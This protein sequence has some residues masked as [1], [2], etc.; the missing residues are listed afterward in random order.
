VTHAQFRA[1]RRP[2]ELGLL[3]PT[4]CP[5]VLVEHGEMIID[6]VDGHEVQIYRCQSCG[7]TIVW[8][9]SAALVRNDYP[10]PR[11]MPAEL[12]RRMD[13]RGGAS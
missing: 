8:D 12:A 1:D 6:S 10:D 7:A 2:V 5:G 13:V 4:E 9:A 3:E 11:R